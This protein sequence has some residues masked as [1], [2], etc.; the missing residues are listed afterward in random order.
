MSNIC[1]Y[2]YEPNETEQENP[3]DHGVESMSLD[4]EA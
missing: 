2:I 1:K 4:V 3:R